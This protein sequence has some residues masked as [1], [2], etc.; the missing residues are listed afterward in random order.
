[1]PLLRHLLVVIVTTISIISSNFSQAEQALETN[2]YQIHYNAFNT[3]VVSPQVAQ[4]FGF[5]RARN[6]ALL[7]IS[8]LDANTKK[9]LMAMVKGQRKNLMGQIYPL[10]FQQIVEQGAIYY[11]AE[12]RFSEAELWQFDIQVQ[13]DPHNPA[14]PLKFTQTFYLQ[15]SH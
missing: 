5:V 9:P 2:N 7:N 3:M 1:M 8:V 12:L 10:E 15:Q 14:I 4:S 6:R 11:I 13:P